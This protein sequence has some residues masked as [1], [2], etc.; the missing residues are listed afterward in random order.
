[1]KRIMNRLTLKK[2][3]EKNFDK[4]TFESSMVSLVFFGARRCKVCREQIPIVES[5]AY[6]YKEKIK[7]YWVDVDK[8]EDLFYRF[9][10]QGI[11]NI[12]IFNN[13]EIVEKIRGLNSEKILIKIVESILDEA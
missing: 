11:P 12:V 6:K 9:R 13:G 2:I 8:H 7:A 4:F 10:L 5:I 3:D 1:M